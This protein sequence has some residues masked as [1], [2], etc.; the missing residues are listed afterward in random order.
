M[1][2]FPNVVFIKVSQF[3][4]GDTWIC[5]ADKGIYVYNIYTDSLSQILFEGTEKYSDYWNNVF[6]IDADKDGYRS[7]LPQEA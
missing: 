1:E 5:T 3:E 2:E 7:I 4:N 6:N